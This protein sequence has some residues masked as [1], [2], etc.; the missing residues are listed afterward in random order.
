VKLVHVAING[1]RQTEFAKETP[2]GKRYGGSAVG[3]PGDWTYLRIVKRTDTAT[4]T[5]LYTAFSASSFN[6]LTGQ[7]NW[8]RGSTWTHN[9]GAAARI[10]IVSMSGSGYTAEFEYFRVSPIAP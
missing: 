5:D 7:L 6:S 3:T 2:G 9:V 4:N 1:T 10:G 8:I